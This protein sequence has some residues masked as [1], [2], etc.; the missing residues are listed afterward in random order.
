MLFLWA[1]QNTFFFVG[2]TS[3]AF[4]Y[5]CNKTLLVRFFCFYYLE[6]NGFELRAIK[7]APTFWVVHNTVFLVTHKMVIF[8]LENK[9]APTGLAL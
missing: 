3:V 7:L 1:A 5:I 8:W 4:I 6:F 2:A 9:F